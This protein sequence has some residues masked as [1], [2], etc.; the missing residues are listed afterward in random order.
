DDL[1]V[2]LRHRPPSIAQERRGDQSASGGPRPRVLGDVC[3]SSATVGPLS[4][5]D[6]QGPLARYLLS[7]YSLWE[8]DGIRVEP[9]GAEASSHERLIA[10][11]AVLSGSAAAP[12][13]SG[14]QRA[15]ASNVA[16]ETPRSSRASSRCP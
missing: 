12:L 1:H 7:P 3:G 10:S 6:C 5:N 15:V 13:E 8:T 2:L 16:S 11:R 9:G 14:D 4:Q